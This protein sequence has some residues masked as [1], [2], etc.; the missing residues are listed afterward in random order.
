[1]TH[2]IPHND[3]VICRQLISDKTKV[4]DSIVYEKEDLPIYEVISIGELKNISNLNVGD[5]IITNSVPTKLDNGN[6]LIREEFI[7]GKIQ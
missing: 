7:A 1:M 2:Y 4:S 5:K 6:Y 3:T